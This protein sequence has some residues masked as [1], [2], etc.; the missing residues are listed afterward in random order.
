MSSAPSE[1]A[2]PRVVLISGGSRGLGAALARDLFERGW[3]VATFSRSRSR[4]IEELEQR[5]RGGERFHWASVDSSDQPTLKAFVLG[6]ARRY[7]RLDA[8]VNNAAFF[9]QGLLAMEKVENVQQ[10]IAVNIAAPIFLARACSRVMLEQ[11]RGCMVNVSSLNAVSGHTGVAVYSATKAALDG[12][13]RS[14]A[15]EL[16]P[17]GIRVNSIAP[18]YFDSEMSSVLSEGDRA[19]II[20][21]TPLGRLGAARDVV[22]AIRFLISDDASFITGHTLRVDGGITC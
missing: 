21:R 11:R 1:G 5:D 19:R 10:M 2:E 8:L 9:S 16:G 3:T 14:L 15:R 22:S 20:R 13:T 17:R 12:L 6:V 7:G 18:G 4:E